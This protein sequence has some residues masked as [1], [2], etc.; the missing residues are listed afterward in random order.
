MF[1]CWMKACPFQQLSLSPLF[2]SFFLSTRPPLTPD[3]YWPV[4]TLNYH[5]WKEKQIR[6]AWNS[7]ADSPSLT[8]Q[9]ENN[10]NEHSL[11][12][13]VEG[14]DCMWVARGITREHGVFWMQD[15][16]EV[17]VH[18][19]TYTMLFTV[20]SA[21]PVGLSITLLPFEFH[22][23]TQ[24]DSRLCSTSRQQ[25]RCEKLLLC[26]FFCTN[27]WKSLEMQNWICYL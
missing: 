21:G 1:L 13:S 16:Q 15:K 7:E 2:L 23:I 4:A 19:Y 27:S 8:V 18:S 24:M 12:P 9:K 3:F 26:F 5:G 10:S 20:P 6:K 11:L 22:F 14:L 17:L 25:T